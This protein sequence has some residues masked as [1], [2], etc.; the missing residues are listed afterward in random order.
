L[1]RSTPIALSAIMEAARPLEPERRSAFLERMAAELAAL[2]APSVTRNDPATAG[3]W[4]AVSQG[5]V[6]GGSATRGKSL[7]R[8]ICRLR[9]PRLLQSRSSE[10]IPNE[11]ADAASAQIVYGPASVCQGLMRGATITRARTC[12]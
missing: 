7:S 4:L 12:S 5:K 11:W 6:C 9:A 8:Y 3:Q 10:Q 1:S 2:S